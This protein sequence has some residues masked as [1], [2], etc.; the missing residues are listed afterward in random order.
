MSNQDNCVW[1][2]TIPLDHDNL[3][4]KRNL[5]G[6]WALYKGD[7]FLHWIRFPYDFHL[8]NPTLEQGDHNVECMNYAGY[9]I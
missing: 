9:Q 6:W 7:D 4:L 3:F 5:S 1:N 2:K 8:N